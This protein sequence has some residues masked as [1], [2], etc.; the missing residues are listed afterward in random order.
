MNEEDKS[1]EWEKFRK[2][3]SAYLRR[4]RAK[5]KIEDF[6]I[7]IQIGKGGYG[8]VFLSRNK[9]TN[10]IV[11]LKR[12]RKKAL[13]AQNE[14]HHIFNERNVLS[15]ANSPWLV[16]LLC[17]F[18]DSSHVYLAME[19]VPGGDMRTLLSNSGV[20][21]EKHARFYLA[22]MTCAIDALHELGFIHRDLKPEN[23]LISS[24]GHLKLTDFGLA[25][26]VLCP[27][28]R[29]KMLER[30]F[31][32]VGSPDYM[33]PE[34]LTQTGYDKLVDY[35]SIGCIFYEFL[36]A[37]PPFG[38]PTIDEIWVNVYHWREVLERPHYTGEDAEFNM[39]DEAWDLITKLITEKEKRI[40]CIDAI[41]KHC[42]FK[43]FEWDFLQDQQKQAAPFIPDL[44]NETDATY[45]TGCV[46][47]EKF[48]FLDNS[49]Y[50]E[51]L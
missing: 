47:D 15:A 21:H 46:Q 48:S 35:W 23:F 13:L 38:A 18:Q 1:K 20:L 11:A 22:E 43:G 51:S 27:E 8:D 6:E 2:K 10:E 3:E 50:K 17:S 42:W 28:F 5:Q 16:K 40:D 45:F 14:I 44:S 26:G 25:K 29:E 41:K 30:A 24:S 4:R 9:D 34:M 7:I 33:A 39:S 36:T 37:F 32:L 31:S 49:K 12:M 19:Y